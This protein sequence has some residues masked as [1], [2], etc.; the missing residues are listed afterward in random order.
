MAK[1]SNAA[2]AKG[3]PEILLIGTSLT[4]GYGL[5]PAESWPA[6]LQQKIDSAGLD[7]SVTNAGVSGET[8]S[9]ALHRIDW[10]LGN[11]HPAVLV[12][13]T[14][15][16]DALRG[17][18]LDSVS[19]NVDA[20]L[21]RLDSISPRPVL[22]VAGMEALPNM[23]RRYVDAFR[24]IFPAAARAH[25]AVYL[26]FLLHGVAGVDSLNQRD[27]IHPNVAG[28]I[29]VTDNVWQVLRPLLD[30]LQQFHP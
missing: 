18:S 21:M 8:S 5:D 1:D 10:L 23:G 25:H 3:R 14:G 16:N 26:P 11:R 13:E 15:A 29:I 20:I 19:A 9:D 2:A 7:F 24:A 4:A 27:G 12:L 17:Q 28:S 6:H 30:S 22:V